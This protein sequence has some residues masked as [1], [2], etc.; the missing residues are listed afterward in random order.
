MD[1][2][3]IDIEQR[4]LPWS[5]GDHMGIPNFFEKRLRRHRRETYLQ[6]RTSEI[7]GLA[8]LGTPGKAARYW[9]ATEFFALI[10]P[11]VS[12]RWFTAIDLC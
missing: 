3:Q 1:Q 4:R 8:D 12:K 11:L 9:A 6:K 7:K 2:V 5:F 10:E